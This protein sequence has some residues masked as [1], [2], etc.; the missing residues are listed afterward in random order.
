MSFFLRWDI[1]KD[2]WIGHLNIKYHEIRSNRLV[3]KNGKSLS[4]RSDWKNAASLWRHIEKC[5]TLARG[6]ITFLQSFRLIQI[7]NAIKKLHMYLMLGWLLWA[8]L[9]WA[10][11]A[12]VGTSTKG[13]SVKGVS[14]RV[15]HSCFGFH[16]ANMLV[17]A[18]SRRFTLSLLR[19]LVLRWLAHGGL[20]QRSCGY[21]SVYHWRSMLLHW[22]EFKKKLVLRMHL[23][24]RSEGKINILACLWF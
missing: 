7:E 11:G 4:C 3:A 15:K 24:L 6:K 17:L 8:L 23:P 20:P 2:N 19:P 1:Y 18:G 5:S 9:V 12:P 21:G 16:C 14:K 22:F 10:R 13:A